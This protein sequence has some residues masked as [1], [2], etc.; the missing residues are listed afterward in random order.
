MKKIISRY[1]VLVALFAGLGFVSATDFRVSALDPYCPE[2]CHK[3]CRA[4][5]QAC[6]AGCPDYGTCVDKCVSSFDACIAY[7]DWVCGPE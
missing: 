1:L 7:C 2:N 6:V 5:L 3:T 4:Q